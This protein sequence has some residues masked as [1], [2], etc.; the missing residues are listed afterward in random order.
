M[1]LRNA[2][3]SGD[4]LPGQ[5]T[6]GPGRA[7]CRDRAGGCGCGFVSGRC[8]RGRRSLG[9]LCEGGGDGH[10]AHP[11]SSCHLSA[12]HLVAYHLSAV[13]L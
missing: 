10:R 9:A 3:F 5:V 12:C 1:P 7:P 4:R 6:L 11:I 13:H 8:A 2:M